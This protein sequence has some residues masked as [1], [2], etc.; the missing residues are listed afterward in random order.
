MRVY[1]KEENEK[2]GA[3]PFYFLINFE[4]TYEFIETF[5]ATAF[6][7][8]ICYIYNKFVFINGVK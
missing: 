7:N 2:T 5:W 8:T 4:M 6:L 3:W 1:K